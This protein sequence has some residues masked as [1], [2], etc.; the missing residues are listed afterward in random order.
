MV[1]W[2]C[3]QVCRDDQRPG[4]DRIVELNLA[5]RRVLAGCRLMPYEELEA[6]W[7]H[8]AADFSCLAERYAARAV[9]EV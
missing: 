4:P 3:V 5:R 2:G 8:V 7:L 9:D 6:T 1:I